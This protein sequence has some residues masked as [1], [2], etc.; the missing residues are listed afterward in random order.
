MLLYWVMIDVFDDQL[1]FCFN[2]CEGVL[3]GFWILQYMQGIN[4]VGYYEYFIIDDCKGGGYL[5]DYQFDYGVLIFGEIYK[6]MIDLFVDS[7]FLQVN[8]YFDNFDVVICFVE[9]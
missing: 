4:V 3:V 6:L 7:V 8:L 9:S 5:L 1:V 2:Q